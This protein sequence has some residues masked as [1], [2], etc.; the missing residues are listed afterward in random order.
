[1][2]A[3]LAAV[4]RRRP[5]RSAVISATRRRL[6]R[7]LVIAAA[8]QFAALRA[9]RQHSGA[10]FSTCAAGR[11]SALAMLDTVVAAA[12]NG[13]ERARA[14]KRDLRFIVV[15]SRAPWCRALDRPFSMERASA[16]YRD[17]HEKWLDGVSIR[18]GASAR[19]TLQGQGDISAIPTAGVRSKSTRFFV[20]TSAGASRVT[21]A[22]GCS[23]ARSARSF[24]PRCG[25]PSAERMALAHGHRTH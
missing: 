1:M 10:D 22:S 12:A 21:S 13:R 2:I 18:D 25:D 8:R 20:W 24:V 19:D 15:S 17:F 3:P 5:A 14:R 7:S 6:T 16:E 23:P 4:T 9:D 11:G